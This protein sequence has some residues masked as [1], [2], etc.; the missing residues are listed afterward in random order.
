MTA[1]ID[2]VTREGLRAVSE[3]Y[4]TGVDRKDAALYLSAFLPDAR[5][6]VHGAGDEKT[7][8]R[9]ISGH[10]ELAGV[11]AA[12]AVYARTFHLVGNAVYD[13][14]ASTASGE[15][16]CIAHHLT[17]ERDGDTNFIMYIRYQDR[18]RQ[19]EGRPWL[20]AERRVLV[21]W[22]ETRAADPFR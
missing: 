11:T 14:N 9:V 18:Y 13:V 2:P 7:P 17:T 22:T 10:A 6:L 3:R 21:D 1:D 19:M 4:A 8:R 16:Y 15:V 20:L 5:L 12:L